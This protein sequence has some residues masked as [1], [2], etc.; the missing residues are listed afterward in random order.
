MIN[1]NLLYSFYICAEHLNISRAAKVLGI[2]QPSLSMQIKTLEAQIGAPVF[3]RNG[4]S[5]S[6]T[7]KGIELLETSGLF[8]DL[9]E[10]INKRLEERPV[11]EPKTSLRILVTQQVERPFVA[12]VV[13]KLARR[14]GR[15]MAI[16]TST[17]EDALSITENNETDILLSHK[18]VETSWNHV[19]VDFPVFFATS[20]EYPAAPAFND[21]SKI[22]KVLDYFGE[23]LIIPTRDTILGQEYYSFAKKHGLKKNIALESNIVSCLVRFVASGSGCAFLPLPYVKSSL[24]QDRIHLVGP[25]QGFWNHCIYIYANMPKKDLETHPLVKNIRNYVSL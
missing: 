6:L 12:E 10:E 20:S 8:H 17:T 1:L 3:L 15:R 5:I 7:T 24:Y 25:R 23:D 4:K 13:A 2:S 16:L 19:K 9:R 18:K 14:G 21:P 22:Q 11:P